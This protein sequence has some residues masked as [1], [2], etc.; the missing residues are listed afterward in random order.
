MGTAEQQ[1]GRGGEW[2]E[3]MVTVMAMAKQPPPPHTPRRL[4]QR[5]TWA[6]DGG[7]KRGNETGGRS[8]RKE[9]LQKKEHSRVEN[10]RAVASRA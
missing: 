10:R 3:G 5:A 8:K 7:E 1:R 4:L 6:R 2:L 9:K